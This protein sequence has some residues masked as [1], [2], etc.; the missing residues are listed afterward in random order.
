M[1]KFI[2]DVVHDFVSS[3]Q[4]DVG[5]GFLHVSN[6]F[7]FNLIFLARLACYYKGLTHW[8]WDNGSHV[9]DDVL[10][11]IFW[12]LITISL[13]FVP[14]API[15]NILALVQIMAGCLWGYKPLPESMMVSLRHIYGSLKLNE[16]ALHACAWE[17]AG[18]NW[19]ATGR[20]EEYCASNCQHW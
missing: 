9:A 14:K 6:V 19:D 18:T 17:A 16:L 10:K 15:N 2:V 13:E 3:L 5:R 12:I 11:C 7:L 20:Y 8:G 1:W 4:P